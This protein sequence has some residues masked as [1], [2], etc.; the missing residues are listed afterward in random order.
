MPAAPGVYKDPTGPSDAMTMVMMESELRGNYSITIAADLL[1]LLGDLG[2]LRGFFFIFKNLRCGSGMRG[3][4][5]HAVIAMCLARSAHIFN[6]WHDLHYE[7]SLI[8]MAVFGVVDFSNIVVAWA[9]VVCLWQK[10][11]TYEPERDR[12]GY[13]SVKKYLGPAINMAIPNEKVADLVMHFVGFYLLWI[14]VFVFTMY[15]YHDEY[16]AGLDGGMCMAEDV[17]WSIALFPQLAMFRRDRFISQGLA[18][19]VFSFGMNRICVAAFLG[20]IPI[21]TGLNILEVIGTRKLGMELMN[22]AILSDFMVLYFYKR[23]VTKQTKGAILPLGNGI[24]DMTIDCN[25]EDLPLSR[26]I[27]GQ[28]FEDNVSLE[29]KPSSAATMTD[30]LMKITQIQPKP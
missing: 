26:V 19:F 30:T 1:V 23:F 8:P 25:Y 21:V 5:M 11:H 24:Y 20:V 3:I 10:S 14:V 15:R 22:I 28:L 2:I 7:P 27:P 18:D 4:S 17:M 29:T 13:E 9:V 12:F 16:E 6:M